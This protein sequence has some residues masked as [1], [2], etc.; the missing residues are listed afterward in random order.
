MTSQGYPLQTAPEHF[1]LPW[2]I[3]QSPR[4]SSRMFRCPAFDIPICSMGVLWDMTRTCRGRSVI[5]NTCLFSVTIFTY[6]VSFTPLLMLWYSVP[7]TCHAQCFFIQYT[8]LHRG[9]PLWWKHVLHQK[10]HLFATQVPQGEP[11]LSLCLW[12]ALYW[13]KTIYINTECCPVRATLAFVQSVSGYLHIMLTESYWNSYTEQ[14]KSSNSN[15]HTS[16]G[17]TN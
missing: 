4:D 13:T 1:G 12:N 14:G 11:L 9:L 6:S 5:S 2:D 3:P 15:N 7:R 17:G 8:T 10:Q 16:L